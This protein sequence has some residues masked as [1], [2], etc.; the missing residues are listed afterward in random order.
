MSVDQSLPARLP[1]PWL[2]IGV[3]N[4]LRGD[5]GVAWE[6]LAELEPAPGALRLRPLQQLTP[7]LAADL[8]AVAAVLFVDAWRP[9]A[10]G[11]RTLP[12]LLPLPASRPAAA[13]WSLSHG[14]QP[15][16]LLALSGL[17]YGVQPCAHQLLIPA[18][19]L[20]HRLGLSSRQRRQLPA[21]RRLLGRWLQ[22]VGAQGAGRA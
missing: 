19:R 8:A 5:D 22:A 14:L 2:V 21:A 6:L 7:D 17:L 18:H 1:P 9:P 4:P 16:E 13:A 10:T 3:G 20:E 15:F 12:R 11:R